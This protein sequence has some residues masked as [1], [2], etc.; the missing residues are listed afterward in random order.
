M[1]FPT[2]QCVDD[3]ATSN[4]IRFSVWPVDI[5]VCTPLPLHTSLI[6]VWNF[7]KGR[8]GCVKVFLTGEQP[9]PDLCVE[10]RHFLPKLYVSLLTGLLGL[11]P[12]HTP[13]AYWL[14]P[15]LEATCGQVIN[16]IQFYLKNS[17]ASCAVTSVGANKH[18][19]DSYTRKCFAGNYCP[20]K[21]TALSTSED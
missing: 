18:S 21:W 16:E 17:A 11:T 3:D 6:G 12:S 9:W 13:H 7:R 15:P 1:N 8:G 19:R 4:A 20:K 14:S 5:S 10:R 2:F